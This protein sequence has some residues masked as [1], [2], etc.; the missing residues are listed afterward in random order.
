MVYK[1]ILTLYADNSVRKSFEIGDR[2][3]K[4]SIYHPS[5]SP[6]VRNYLHEVLKDKG[7]LFVESEV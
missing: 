3:G 6:S 7:H 5:W 2:C 4:M 1:L